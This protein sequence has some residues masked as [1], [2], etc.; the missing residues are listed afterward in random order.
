MAFSLFLGID[1]SG[2]G[3]ADARLAGLQVCQATCDA[4]TPR[5]LP[6]PSTRKSIRNWTRREVAE[7]VASLVESEQQFFLGIDHG[8]SFP[9]DYFERN[10]LA[11][12]DRF[13]D[14]FVQ[15]WPTDQV[16]ETVASVRRT[17]LAKQRTGQ[18]T[19]LRLTERWSSSAKS[20]FH[21]DV[22]GSVA[23]S[24][25]AGLP[26]LHK[27]RR[28]F[29]TRLHFWPFDGWSLPKNKSVI[30]EVYPSLFYQ[31]YPRVYKQRDQQDAYAIARWLRESHQRSILDHYLHPPLTTTEKAIARLEGWILGIT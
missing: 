11:T 12:W 4:P 17:A 21:F 23:S 16:G 13:L 30:A 6:A 20:V 2:A 14:D 3:T 5:L 19:E 8:L 29:G 9:I 10:A 31:R 22:Q 7:Y 26:F 1:Y 28:Q 15:H 27:L 25:H 24:T 18:A